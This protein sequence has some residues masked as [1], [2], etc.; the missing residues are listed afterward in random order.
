MET[1]YIDSSNIILPLDSEINLISINKLI[2]D[3]VA[4]LQKN[5]LTDSKV[6]DVANQINI[7]NNDMRRSKSI[8]LLYNQCPEIFK[9]I[10]NI[11]NMLNDN[12]HICLSVIPNDID[13][14]H[15]ET[16][17]FFAKH[18]DFVP[19]K[20]KYIEYYSILYCIDAVCK[21]GETC[22]YINNTPVK[23]SETITRNN[24]LIFRNDIEHEGLP[25]LSGHKTILKANIVK[26]NF[27]SNELYN[28][29]F[30]MLI[31]ARNDIISK[32]KSSKYNI[33]PIFSINEY[34]FY[35]KSFE[36]DHCVVPFQM[37]V[38][39]KGK[40]DVGYEQISKYNTFDKD[41]IWFSIGNNQVLKSVKYINSNY[42]N[43]N[44]IDS[45]EEHNLNTYVKD[46]DLQEINEV[47]RTIYM[48]IY[49]FWK[50]SIESKYEYDDDCGMRN[51]IDNVDD[52]ST[53][54]GEKIKE[55]IHKIQKSEYKLFKLPK[56]NKLYSTAI[57]DKI[58]KKK[59]IDKIKKK[60]TD[61]STLAYHV[62]S[63]VYCNQH[64]YIEYK[65]DI[66]FGFINLSDTNL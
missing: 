31:D 1:L 45:I 10:S 24:W 26:I 13:I 14:I 18:N 58:C 42:Q 17:D 2:Q 51:S 41:I 52:A 4:N 35:R 27:S 60:F 5:I 28:P 49:Y 37:I 22:L 40:S 50:V 54:I 20:S 6:Y 36:D 15:Y 66:N 39:A 65:L 9:N 33:L 44:D 29:A 53:M 61:S 23:F 43:D 16:G 34:L 12:Y 59:Y 7:I 47:V 30:S 38:K 48:T 56:I 11:I 25:I 57:A 8:N 62:G 21:G 55:N 32:F 63:S 46:I 64:E 3:D 19:I